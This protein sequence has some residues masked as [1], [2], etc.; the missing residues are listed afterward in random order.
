[1]RYFCRLLP[2]TVS[3]LL[4]CAFLL[5]HWSLLSWNVKETA[6]GLVYSYGWKQSSKEYL[7]H[8]TSST[9]LPFLTELYWK[10]KGTQVWILKTATWT[11]HLISFYNGSRNP[12]FSRLQWSFLMYRELGSVILLKIRELIDQTLVL[13]ATPIFY[14]HGC[15]LFHKVVGC[16]PFPKFNIEFSQT[17]ILYVL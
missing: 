4:S 16:N 5:L 7:L 15:L 8:S 17:S 6:L 2:F 3:F 14:F 12:T 1:M 13:K 10:G 9:V 11:K